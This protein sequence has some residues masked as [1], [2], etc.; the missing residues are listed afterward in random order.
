MPNPLWL[1]RR[2]VVELHG[3]VNG[4]WRFG[5]V[6]HKRSAWIRPDGD[7]PEGYT[8]FGVVDHGAV[9]ASRL[10]LVALE[11]IASADGSIRNHDSVWLVAYGVL[12]ACA[13]ASVEG[14]T[15]ALRG[16]PSNRVDPGL[17]RCVAVPTDK[18][19]LAISSR[20]R[21]QD[22]AVTKSRD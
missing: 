22:R 14:S 15:A 20:A 17:V 11:P 19:D 5:V 9:R 7:A 4:G 8:L 1:M 13:D 21:S 6:C 12:V 3:R 18:P 2:W 10:E 16:W